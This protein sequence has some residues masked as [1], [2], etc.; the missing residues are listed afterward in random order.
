MLTTAEATR[1]HPCSLPCSRS[2]RICLAGDPLGT[3][4]NNLTFLGVGAVL[5]N[6]VGTTGAAMLLVRP[7]LRA[8]SERTKVRH[9]FVFLIFV[10]C[11][12]G[13]LLTPLGDPPLFLGFLHGRELHLDAAPGA[14]VAP[15][16]R[17]SCSPSS[18]AR[19][20]LLPAGA[21]LGDRRSTSRVRAHASAR[22][23][24]PALPRR[25]DRGGG[26]LGAAGHA[27]RGVHVAVPARARH[28]GHGRARAALRARRAAAPEPLRLG[29][30]RRGRDRLRGIF[31]TMVP[32]LPSS[33]PTATSSGSRC[34]GSAS[35]PRGALVVPRQR[36]HLP[37]LHGRPPGLS[38]A[39]RPPV[40]C[41]YPDVMPG[42]AAAP[43]A[44]PAAI[45][46]GA[47]FMGANTYIGNAPNFMV[48][49]RRGARRPPCPTSS[50]ATA[51]GAGAARSSRSPTSSRSGGLRAH[52]HACLACAF[53][54][55]YSF[56]APFS[57]IGAATYLRK[58]AVP[59]RH[60]AQ[61]V[62]W[63]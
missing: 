54:V 42:F 2:R 36:P 57:A 18:S 33:R 26:A 25:R 63:A 22:R 9:I 29:A 62:R 13:G 20:L 17:R 8:N 61:P 46:C 10:V 60:R 24:Q 28:A 7:M 12:L 35:G 32:A 6:L 48:V 39:S 37:R 31:A 50:T 59:A 53:Y 3:P 5:A 56:I 15:G 58:I 44:V 1:L 19:Q 43:A 49:H 47:V 23:D 45:S 40:G 51:G 27:R 52:G 21:A 11:N 55:V 4:R 38:S 34:R 16:Q 30:Y 14:A 41:M